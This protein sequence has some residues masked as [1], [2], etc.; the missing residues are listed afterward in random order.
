M[1][2][3][4]GNI[5]VI[6]LGSSLVIALA[7]AGYFYFQSQ[8]GQPIEKNKPNYTKTI[9]DSKP[10]DETANWKTYTGKH[11]SFKYPGEWQLMTIPPGLTKDSIEDM[12][13][14]ITS[15]S[16]FSVTAYTNDYQKAL[17]Y[18]KSNNNPTIQRITVDSHTGTRLDI[19]GHEMFS[20]LTNVFIRG[21][22]DVTY[23]VIG[24][25]GEKKDLTEEILNVIFSTFKFL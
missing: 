14:R 18:N 19:D 8:L 9:P 3:Q 6:L 7:L 21:T 13:L 15:S 20:H 5:L 11:F 16:I 17:D 2:K 24:F 10:V 4:Q 25:N 1:K 23:F 12:S 22:G